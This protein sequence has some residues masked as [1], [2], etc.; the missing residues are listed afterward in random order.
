[1][2]LVQLKTCG[3]TPRCARRRALPPSTLGRRFNLNA[4][5]CSH[6]ARPQLFCIGPSKSHHMCTISAPLALS[7]GENIRLHDGDV[8]EISFEGLGR[9]PRNTVHAGRQGLTFSGTSALHGFIA[10]TSINTAADL[11]GICSTP[12]VD[13]ASGCSGVATTNLPGFGK[14]TLAVIDFV[15]SMF[16]TTTERLPV[17]ATK[18]V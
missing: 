3:A 13:E 12:D 10:Y 2:R 7:F 18:T 6:P 15:A 14:P 1:M 16:T 9:L 5:D 8:V 4:R 11:A 17:D